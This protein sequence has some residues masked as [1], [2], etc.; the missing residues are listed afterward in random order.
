MTKQGLPIAH[1]IAPSTV[2]GPP[3][4]EYELNDQGTAEYFRLPRDALSSHEQTDDLSAGLGFI[5]D[6]PRGE[7]IS[8]LK[9]RVFGL[10]SG[11][12]R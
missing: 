8:L 1:E 3:R 2:D 5:V 12:P 11:A 9:E 7:A 4:L 10:E 6:L